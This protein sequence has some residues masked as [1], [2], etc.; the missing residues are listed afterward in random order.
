MWKFDSIRRNLENWV[1]YWYS[2]EMFKKR[3]CLIRLINSGNL[4]IIT[5][6]NSKFDL[7]ANFIFE[8]TI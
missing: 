6:R 7:K 8:K 1:F 5:F 4:V 3:N 2:L